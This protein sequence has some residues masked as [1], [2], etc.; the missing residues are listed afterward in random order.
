MGGYLNIGNNFVQ[1][2]SQVELSKGIILPNGFPI[3]A[4]G[5]SGRYGRK[6]ASERSFFQ[7]LS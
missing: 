7:T 5:V 4:I 2:R 1:L 6:C 3:L